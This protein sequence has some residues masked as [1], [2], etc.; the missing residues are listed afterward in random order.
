VE[1]SVLDFDTP[2][3]V[4]D[5]VS[6]LDGLGYRR[7]WLG[8]H[9]SHFQCANPVLLGALLAGATEGIRVGS[10][11]V[12][13]TYHSPYKVA[14]DARLIEF[15][16]PDRFDLG[17]TR[18]LDLDEA[19]ASAM[20]DG[21]PRRDYQEKFADL[22]GFV[23]GRLPAD[24]PLHGRKP[25]LEDA[26][27]IWMLG[28]GSGSARLAAR[29]GTGL[30][31][32]LHHAPVEIDGVALIDEYRRNFE[33]SPEFPE[34]AVIIAI[35]CICAD[36]EAKAR[37]YQEDYGRFVDGYAPELRE[38]VFKTP[39]IVGSPEQCRKAFTDICERYG[40]NEIMIADLLGNHRYAE[41]LEM[42]RL[43]ASECGLAP[44]FEQEEMA[45]AVE[46]A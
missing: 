14:E 9:H 23:T 3:T 45:L 34:P 33:P 5:F 27:P 17:V 42:F 38:K 32:S 18:G 11:G 4:V 35:S 41:R 22:H 6:V 39:M 30:C 21:Q 31:F 24:H 26:P 12:C 1:L 28:L 25:Y 15:M 8:E 37:E 44:R 16:L 46:E 20:L 19:V 10:G 2:G 29:F 36:T 43:L 40:T 13:L 7:Y